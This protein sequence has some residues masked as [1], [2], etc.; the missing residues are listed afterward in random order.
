[1][2]AFRLF[3]ANLS[4]II[5]FSSDS[6][7]KKSLDKDDIVIYTRSIDTSSFNEF[8]AEATFKGSIDDIKRILM[9]VDS[10]HKWMP[11]CKSAKVVENPSSSEITY[12]MKLRVP[13]PFANRD[14]IQ[15]LIFHEQADS[16]EIDIINRPQKVKKQK[17]YVRMQEAKGRWIIYK[18]SDDEISVRFQY[19]A[20]PGGD[21][22]AW[23]VNSFVVKNP[24]TTI[25]N[26]RQMMAD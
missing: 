11:D 12:H 20:D 10:Y 18:I 17:K 22:P 1:M 26:M 21:I 16:L 15:Q 14:I 13:F 24:H 4:I 2:F 23:L 6:E 8:L 9:D 3:L 25:K 5:I 7:W 19:F